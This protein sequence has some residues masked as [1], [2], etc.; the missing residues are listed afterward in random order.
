MLHKTKGIIL[1]TIKYGET[2]IIASVY[3]ESFGLQS[4]IVKGV[5]KASKKTSSKENFFLAA[6]ILDMQVYHNELKNLQFIKEFQWAFLYQT[7]FFDVI[8]N[9]VA[10]YIVELFHHCI[11]QPENNSELFYFLNN[12]LINLDEKNKS[13]TA[14]LPLFFTLHLG[15]LLG[16]EFNG[17][18]SE[19]MPVL[20]LI[21]GSF[22]KDIPLHSYFLQNDEARIT[23]Q[24]ASA[25]FDELEKIQ[26]NKKMRRELLQSYLQYISFHISDFKTLKS[27]AVLQQI[28]S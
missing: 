21:E 28:L 2:S 20:D 17:K 18:F 4:Y 8:K 10:M 25:N 15:R 19:A 23:S 9:A 24:I 14:N 1:R 6:A 12:S 26:L 7:I 11:K 3:T 5:R 16:F 22:V 13:F 27:I